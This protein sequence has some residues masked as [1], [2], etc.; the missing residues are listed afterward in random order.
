MNERLIESSI[1]GDRMSSHAPPPRF[2][3]GRICADPVCGTRL[4]VYNAE[5]YCSIHGQPQPGAAEGRRRRRSRATRV[6][7]TAPEPTILAATLPET[8]VDGDTG[9][10]RLSA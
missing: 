2:A 4:S 9:L 6:A 5:D 10:D 3:A 8:E 7:T 1:T